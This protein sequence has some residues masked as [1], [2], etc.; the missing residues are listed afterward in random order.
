M[1]HL[2]RLLTRFYDELWWRVGLQLWKRSARR[3]NQDEVRR[4]LGW[5]TLDCKENQL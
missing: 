4:R 2:R 5:M 3:H 1:K